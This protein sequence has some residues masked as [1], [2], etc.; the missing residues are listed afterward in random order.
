MH[1]LCVSCHIVKSK[2]M[3]DKP[4]LAQC[5]SC[6][7]TAPPDKILANLKWETTLPHFDRVIL[8]DIDTLKI[9]VR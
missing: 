1:K 2:E 8:P 5:S 4:N 9:K 7:S 6:H 3:K